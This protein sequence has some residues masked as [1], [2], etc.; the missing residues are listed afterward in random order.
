MEEQLKE[1]VSLLED[2]KFALA[3]IGGIL[4]GGATLF[5]KIFHEKVDKKRK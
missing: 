1:I 2:I 3:A 4:V 5:Y